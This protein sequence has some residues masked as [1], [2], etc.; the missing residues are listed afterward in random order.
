M[1]EKKTSRQYSLL[2][3]CLMELDKGLKTIWGI[4]PTM[5]PNPAN[6]LAEPTLSPAERRH[7]ARLMRVNHAGEVSA[8]ALYQAQ[9]L[10]ARSPEVRHT[11]QKSAQEENDH[12]AWCHQRLKELGSHPSHLN[13]L[14]FAG[15]FL[16]GL[17]AG[18]ASDA[19]SLGFVAETEHQ[20]VNHLQGHLNSL[21]QADYKSR[22][23]ITQMAEDEAHHG[24]MAITA[25]AKELPKM[26]KQAMKLLSKVMTTTAYW[27]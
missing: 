5:R 26:M 21:S 13:P 14:W 3:Y 19:L 9:A 17:V 2:D 4:P 15:S 18:L 23:I 10:T 6:E 16:I 22:Q 1:L 24:T 27:V 11:M 8:Q 7:S 20:V 12:L 25:G